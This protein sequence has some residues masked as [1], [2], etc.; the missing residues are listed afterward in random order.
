MQGTRFGELLGRLV[1]L[2][3]HDIC[4]ILEEQV[5]TSRK[6]GQI[7]LGWDLCKPQHVWQAWSV[8]LIGR[9]PRVDLLQ[10]GV[11]AQATNHVP[12]RVAIDLGVIPVRTYAGG[13][14]VAASEKNIARAV[15]TLPARIRQS[16]E[17][18]LADAGQV[19][20]AI[21]NYY[22]VEIEQMRRRECA[23]RPCAS[24]CA[25]PACSRRNSESVVIEPLRNVG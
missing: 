8:Q 10:L 4:E 1:E 2:S 11:D 23:N 15:E 25:G 6:F 7:A 5:R 12:A 17:F 22:A 14:V 16:A 20:S 18:V 9:V 19:S 13:I 3:H 24:R 21:A